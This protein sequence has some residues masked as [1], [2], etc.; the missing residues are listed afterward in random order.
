MKLLCVLSLVILLI[1]KGNAACYGGSMPLCNTCSGSCP[2]D[3][4][5]ACAD[6]TTDC[7]PTSSSEC[8]AQDNTCCPTNYYWDTAS[9]CCSDTVNCSPACNSDEEC[10]AVNGVATCACNTTAYQGL[11]S[12]SIAPTVKCESDTMIISISKCLLESLGYDSSSFQLNNNSDDCTNTYPEVIDGKTMNSIQA[13]PQTGWCGNIVTMDTTKVYYT[14]TLHIGT[15]NSSSGIIT[16]NPANINFTC[17]Y[18]LTMET[19]LA[20]AL[21]PVVSSVNITVNGEGTAVT[22]MGAYWDASYSKPIETNEDVPV[23]SDLYLG[24]FSQFVDGDKFALRVE[25]CFATPDGD[26]NNVNKVQIVSGG[27]P[28]NQGVFAQVQQ[29]GEAL[30]ARVKISSFAFRDYPLVYISCMARLCDR[31]GTCTGCNLGRAANS[32]VGQVQIMVNFRG[33]VILALLM[34]CRRTAQPESPTVS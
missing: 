18:N 21:H 23:G 27:C 34:S 22:T 15:G 12:S 8:P 7:V 26:Q 6:E 14:N 5:C 30:E 20:A 3:N 28:A 4:P 19:S 9:N 32:E 33:S 2:S 13:I 1:E 29:N 25:T 16:V 17:S 10:K 11:T 31:N 24:L